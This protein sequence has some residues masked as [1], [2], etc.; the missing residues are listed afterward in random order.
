M[1]RKEE[2]KERRG[3]QAIVTREEAHKHLMTREEGRKER[4]GT[5]ASRDERRGAH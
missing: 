3:G 4:R 2:R 1:T 5:Q